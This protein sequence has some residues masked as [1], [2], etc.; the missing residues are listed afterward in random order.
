MTDAAGR[1]AFPQ[2][3]RPFTAW[4]LLPT[5]AVIDQMIVVMDGGGDRCLPR[6]AA[7][8]FLPLTELSGRDVGC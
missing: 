4:S 2:A 1:F 5:E 3:D 8:G 6:M 7:A